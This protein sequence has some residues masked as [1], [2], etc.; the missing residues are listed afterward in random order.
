MFAL[1]GQQ[2]TVI[3]GF[4]VRPHQ[5][6]IGGIYIFFSI[7]MIKIQKLYYLAEV[8]SIFLE[9]IDQESAEKAMNNLA[10]KKYNNKEIKMIFIPEEVYN[11]NFK[12][13]QE[14]K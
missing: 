7:N 6:A 13:L 5:A 3:N 14:L 8:G 12:G 2:G 9:F 4:I 10:G 11:K 1:F